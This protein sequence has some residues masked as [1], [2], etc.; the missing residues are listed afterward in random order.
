METNYPYEFIQLKQKKMKNELF[1]PDL[2]TQ[3][4]RVLNQADLPRKTLVL[5]K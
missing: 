4:S 2:N 3:K 1:I 5:Q